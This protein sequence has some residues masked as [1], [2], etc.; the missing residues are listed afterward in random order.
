[1]VFTYL[2]KSTGLL[3][4]LETE[5]LFEEQLKKIAVEAINKNNF[6]HLC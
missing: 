3:F 1:M 2:V 5:D 4:L 6:F